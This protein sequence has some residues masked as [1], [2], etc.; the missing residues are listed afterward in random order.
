MYWC[1]RVIEYCAIYVID[2]KGSY[3]VLKFLC[4]HV[5]HRIISKENNKYKI[6]YK[7]T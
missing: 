2:I 7:H 5:V 3:K 4:Y 6:D 1:G